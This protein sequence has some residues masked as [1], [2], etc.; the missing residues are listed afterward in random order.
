M[1]KFFRVQLNEF[2]D[3]NGPNEVLTPVG[4]KVKDP[5]QHHTETFEIKKL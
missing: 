3:Q 2:A 4:M 5:A 1:L